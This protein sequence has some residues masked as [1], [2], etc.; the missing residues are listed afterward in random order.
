MNIK[1][2]ATDDRWLCHLEEQ[3]K[4][5]LLADDRGLGKTIQV[6][7]FLLRQ[8]KRN[9]LKPTLIVLPIAL[10][11]NWQEEIRKFAP[12]LNRS[13]YVHK[14]SGRYKSAEQISQ[15]DIILTSYDTLKIDQLILGKID[16]QS[17]ICDEAQNV[18]S[19][20]SQRSRALRAMKYEFRLAMGS[21]LFGMG[22]DKIIVGLTWS[23]CGH[24]YEAKPPI[25]KE[26][27][28]S[29]NRLSCPPLHVKP[30]KLLLLPT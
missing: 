12:S 22:K 28:L 29:H 10:I 1:Y 3:G 16:F 11:E 13:I 24:D 20:S 25:N 15:F 4:G 19:H 27:W 30:P 17:I 21:S 8:Q 5:G 18:K 6:I 9:K 14:G 7:A 26:N 23:L 2:K